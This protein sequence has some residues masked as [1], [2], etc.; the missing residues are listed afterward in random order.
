M[1]G[2]TLNMAIEW[3]HVASVLNDF[4]QHF[5]KL[6]RDNLTLA[7]AVA[8]GDLAKSLKYEVKSGSSFVAVD[9]SLLDYW[10][11]V[12]HGRKPGKF[13]PLNAIERWIRVRRI[14]P[15]AN[16]GKVPT[17]RQLAYLIARKIA[18]VGTKPRPIFATSLTETMAAMDAAL[19]EAVT[20]DIEQ[21]IDKFI[22]TI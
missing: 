22:T 7:D 8:S 11:Y 13:P 1:E 3:P 21:Q 2:A 17:V 15:Y 20:L 10:Y 19:E 6:Y 18:R 12:E 9:V 14:V 16:N 4:G 5:V